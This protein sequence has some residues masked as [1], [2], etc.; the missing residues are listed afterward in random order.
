MPSST[1]APP[2]H[3]SDIDRGYLKGLRTLKAY[4]ERI[5]HDIRS[6]E[7]IERGDEG[8]I[9]EDE[10]SALAKTITKSNNNPAISGT[11]DERGELS[12]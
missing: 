4:F 7:Y 1:L 6:E 12:V 11:E 9:T 8:G 10:G 3:P 5:L 2:A